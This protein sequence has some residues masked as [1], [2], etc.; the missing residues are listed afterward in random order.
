MCVCVYEHFLIE[1]GECVH[2]DIFVL[3]S[4]ESNTQ[5][6]ASRITM[7]SA[8]L[9]VVIQNSYRV[10]EQGRLLS[11][12]LVL[13]PSPNGSALSIPSSWKAFSL[14]L[15]DISHPGV[16][17]LS[18]IPPPPP[19]VCVVKPIMVALAYLITL[20]TTPEILSK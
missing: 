2:L 1:R 13:P 18:P 19:C 15:C 10:S 11:S 4:H 12:S 5:I 6:P 17:S 8:P 14:F 20:K 7:S 16:S 9:I 3:A